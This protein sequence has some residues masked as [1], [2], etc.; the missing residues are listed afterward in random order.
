MLGHAAVDDELEEATAALSDD[1]ARW[2]LT[3]LARWDAEH[4]QGGQ[5]RAV[6]DSA[7]LDAVR[8]A[9]ER[10]GLAGALAVIIDMPGGEVR[11]ALA[12]LVLL[13]VQLRM[14]PPTA[15]MN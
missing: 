15:S 5:V 11:A 7:I 8:E 1:Q 4:D 9:A 10:G 3:C 14:I 6:V 12:D 2:G 13:H